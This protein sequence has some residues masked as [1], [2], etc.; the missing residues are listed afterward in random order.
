MVPNARRGRWPAPRHPAWKSTRIVALAPRHK[1]RERLRISELRFSQSSIAATLQDGRPLAQVE[2]DL[3]AG[4]IC[5]AALGPLNVV[6]FRGRWFSRDNR[7]LHILR[8]VL[9]PGQYVRVHFGHVDSLFLSHFSTHNEGDTIRVRSTKGTEH[10]LTHRAPSRHACIY[11]EGGA[12]RGS[13][14]PPTG[15]CLRILRRL[16]T[17]G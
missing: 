10:W 14:S 6:H 2:N 8:R 7:R 17:K 4:R 15:A 3:R 1:R 5:G 11:S 12:I 9:W 16:E 13:A